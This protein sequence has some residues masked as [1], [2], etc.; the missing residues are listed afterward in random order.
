MLETPVYL[1]EHRVLVFADGMTAQDGVLRIWAAP[2]YQTRVLPAFRDMLGLPFERVLF[3]H[4][5]PSTTGTSSWPRSTGRPGRG[6]EAG[7]RLPR[8]VHRQG[9]RTCKNPAL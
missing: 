1:P 7:R 3:S 9:R 4:G 6:D 8:G 2:G 5:E